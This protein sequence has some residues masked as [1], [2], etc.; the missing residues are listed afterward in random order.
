MFFFL[1]LYADEHWKTV[2]GIVSPNFSTNKLKKMFLHIKRNTDIL[3]DHLKNKMETSEP[4]EL[5]ELILRFTM[6]T[7]ASTV[8]GL[9]VNS[10]K[11]GGND[12][13]KHG[14]ALISCNERFLFI[15]LF[16]NLFKPFLNL[17][18]IEMIP[19]E[20]G[21]FFTRFVDKAYES[22][23]NRDRNEQRADFIQLLMEARDEEKVRL[24]YDDIQ[25]G[26]CLLLPAWVCD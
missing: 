7:I 13:T 2:R 17:I 15:A 26:P 21:D 6:D 9:E 11:D 22:N 23:R 14:H 10:M 19:K 16:L 20:T 1:I 25:V 18:G 12:F 8:F 4:V 5:K 24:T 3:V